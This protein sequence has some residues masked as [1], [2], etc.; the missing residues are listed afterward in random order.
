[1][2]TFSFCSNHP[3]CEDHTDPSLLHRLHY[4]TAAHRPD[5]HSLCDI[6]MYDR[7]KEQRKGLTN[8]FLEELVDI[9]NVFY[10]EVML[11]IVSHCQGLKVLIKGLHSG[12]KNINVWQIKCKDINGRLHFACRSCKY[13]AFISRL[14]FDWIIFELG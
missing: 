6:H 2:D 12:G 9:S 4:N 11:V 5:T 10:S 7:I 3:R 1:M 14:K 8:D 13:D